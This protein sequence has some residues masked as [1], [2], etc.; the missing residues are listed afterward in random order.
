MVFVSPFLG[1]SFLGL[2]SF[3]DRQFGGGGLEEF[4]TCCSCVSKE[5]PSPPHLRLDGL[6]GRNKRSSH[7]LKDLEHAQRKNK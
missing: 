4:V 1:G 6:L 5:S 2:L 3:E 7:K